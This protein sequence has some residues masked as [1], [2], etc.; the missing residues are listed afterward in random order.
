MSAFA[1]AIGSKADMRFCNAHVKADIAGSRITPRTAGRTV[2][3][4]RSPRP[5][6]NVFEFHRLI[7]AIDRAWRCGTILRWRVFGG[8]AMKPKFYVRALVIAASF[9]TVCTISSP[10]VAEVVTA[11]DDNYSVPVDGILTVLAPGIFANDVGLIA[12]D[13]A[14][15]V[16]VPSH[17]FLILVPNTGEFQYDPFPGFSGVDVWTY[18]IFNG[19]T[20]GVVSNT[21]TVRIEVGTPNAVPL[22]A[23]LPLFVT[24]LGA[25][26]LFGWRRKKKAAALAA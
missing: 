12:T 15:F 24:G 2:A 17:G 9:W 10:G 14:Q 4:Q 1:V 21:A 25:L 7:T 6:K 16:T 26:G 23:A 11:N 22:P 18:N 8:V 20:N 3:A 13:A 19:D 5:W